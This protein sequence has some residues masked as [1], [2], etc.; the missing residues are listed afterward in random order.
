MTIMIGLEIIV[1][2]RMVEG[3]FGM[4]LSVARI[5]P[6]SVSDFEEGVSRL[7]IFRNWM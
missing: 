7:T 6:F 3:W 4:S 5:M 2:S 1:G